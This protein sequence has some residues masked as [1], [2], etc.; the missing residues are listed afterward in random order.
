MRNSR[1]KEFSMK[2]TIKLLKIIALVAAIGFSVIA[3]DNGTTSGGGGGDSALNGSWRDN[4]DGTVLRLNNGSLSATKDGTE[5]LRGTYTASGGT[6]TINYTHIYMDA[7][8]ARQYN[9]SP[10]LKTKSQYLDIQRAYGNSLGYT[11]SQINQVIA[12]IEQLFGPFSYTYS[13]SGNTMRM[14]RSGS[15]DTYTKI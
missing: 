6:I 14:T 9:T 15:T 13:V 4:D 3:C 10:G 12:T 11:Q 7:Q 1:I 8:S 2:N 5:L